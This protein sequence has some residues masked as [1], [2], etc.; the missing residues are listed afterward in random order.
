MK[1]ILPHIAL[2][3]FAVAVAP[4]FGQAGY[5][6]NNTPIT[7]NAPVV[8]V[9]ATDPSA[10]ETGPDTGTFTVRRTGPTNSTLTA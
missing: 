5:P 9:L 2:A 8:T 1:M 10:S 6:T 7:N 4:A 3:L